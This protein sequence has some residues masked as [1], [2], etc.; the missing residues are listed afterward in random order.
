MDSYIALYIADGFCHPLFYMLM[1]IS[2]YYIYM[3]IFV[4]IIQILYI[5]LR[6]TK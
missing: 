6:T 1:C 3:H 5:Y 2:T 4:I